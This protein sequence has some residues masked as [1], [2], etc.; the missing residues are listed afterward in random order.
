MCND[1]LLAFWSCNRAQSFNIKIFLDRFELVIS[2]RQCSFQKLRW[3]YGRKKP[4]TIT[5]LLFLQHRWTLLLLFHVLRDI[6]LR[7]R[8]HYFRWDRVF[9]NNLITHFFFNLVLNI[10]GND[11]LNHPRR[12]FD[13]WFNLKQIWY[14]V[15]LN[16]F[17]HLWYYCFLNYRLLQNVTTI[18]IDILF[19]Y[20]WIGI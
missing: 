15:V 9:L 18:I 1:L 6:L 19:Y 8:L 3:L 2:V 20:C 11:I 13:I 7:Q 4:I 14:Q 5:H 17:S 12:F 16:I 10:V